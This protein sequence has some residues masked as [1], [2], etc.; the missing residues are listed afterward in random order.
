MFIGTYQH[1]LDSKNRLIIP[2]KFRKQLGDAF[3]VTKWME[4]SLHAF[5]LE[6]WELFSNQI[7]KLPM[8][9]SDARR[10]KRFVFSGAVEAEFDKQGRISLPRTLRQYA[11]IEKDVVIFGTGDD[12]FEIWGAE[13]WASYEDETDANFDDIA[14][15]LVDLGF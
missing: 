4:H 7:K 14:D 1:T 5:T 11:E 12:S 6:G 15:G 2:A 9:N 13:Q 10:F 8:T 3:V